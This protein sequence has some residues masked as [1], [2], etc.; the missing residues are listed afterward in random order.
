VLLTA[1]GEEIQAM[2]LAAG[3]TNN[4]RRIELLVINM[5]MRMPLA[6]E[7]EDDRN[8]VRR[9]IAPEHNVFGVGGDDDDIS[10]SELRTVENASFVL[11]IA[12][13]VV[14]MLTFFSL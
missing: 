9:D 4:A 5:M 6:K 7:E 2:Q 13:F 11:F 14:L 3:S 10:S 1:D 8:V 12:A